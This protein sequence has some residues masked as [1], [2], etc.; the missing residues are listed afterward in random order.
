MT[1]Q[2]G[3]YLETLLQINL[4]LVTGLESATTFIEHIDNTTEE[5]RKALI[6]QLRA[7]TQASRD[8][9]AKK[10]VH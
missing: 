4:A 8:V 1:N 5:Q 7:L 6:G 3:Q 9:F 2:K 10:Q